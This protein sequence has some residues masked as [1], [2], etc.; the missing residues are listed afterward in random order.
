MTDWAP[1]NT[2]LPSVI[3]N[4]LNINYSTN[5]LWAATFG[6]GMWK[7]TKN[8]APN[9]V[10][11]IAAVTPAAITVSPNPSHGSLRL[12]GADGKTAW[13]QSGSFDAA[14]NLK[15]ITT[16]LPKGTYICEVTNAG[17]AARNKVILY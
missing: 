16:D 6:R 11:N 10:A 2:N 7:T 3:I 4:D 13:L 17:I 1:Y 8:E 9:S 15:V 12:L 14:G 5:E